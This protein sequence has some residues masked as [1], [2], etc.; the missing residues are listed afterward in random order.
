MSWRESGG[1]PVD[2]PARSGFGAGVIRD[3]TRMNLSGDVRLDY[4][5]SGVVWDLDCPLEACIEEGGERT[6]EPLRDAVRPETVA[7]RATGPRRVL[8]VE[9]EALVA[10]ELAQALAGP[11]HEVVGPAGSVRQALSLLKDA[12]CDAAVLDV[13][14]GGETAEAI[15]V[16]LAREGTPF[17]ILSGYDCSQSPNAFQSARLLPNP[18]RRETLLAEVEGC[19]AH[20]GA[21]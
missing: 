18:V 8:L 12:S 6:A 15:A 10:L 14:L 7:P 2:P 20:S 4:A 9:D 16:Q 1:P 13:Q 17:L 21:P 5:R 19:L 11:G 3:A